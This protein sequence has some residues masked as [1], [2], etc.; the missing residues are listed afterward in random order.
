M[1]RRRIR[2]QRPKRRPG[3]ML[4]AVWLL[5]LL[6]ALSLV[7]WRQTTGVE[8]ERALRDIETERG[9]AEAERIA[10]SRRIEE[11]RSRSRVVGVARDRLG[12]YIPDDREIVFLPAADAR[13][14]T[15]GVTR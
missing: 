1:K 2:P 12:M 3:I 10:A 14:R 13:P 5:L 8:M 6:G 7:T 4:A 9:I 11:L 15:S